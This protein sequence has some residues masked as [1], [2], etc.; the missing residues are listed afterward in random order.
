MSGGAVA[1]GQ[2]SVALAGD[3]VGSVIVTG[4]GNT[5]KLDLGGIDGDLLNLLLKRGPEAPTK[6]PRP[7]PVQV[8][9]PPF[10]DHLDREDET[11]TVL[12]RAGPGAPVNVYGEEGVGKTYLL[13]HAAN[14]PGAQ[15]GAPD[16]VVFLDGR[17]GQR[18][19][20]LQQLFDELFE[21]QP[22]VVQPEA[23]N[24]RDLR[25]KQ[26][27]VVIDSFELERDEAQRLFAGAPGCRFVVASSSRLV[28]EGTPLQLGGLSPA[29]ALAIVERELGPLVGAEQAAAGA[30]GAALG[31]NAL[32]IRQAA[33]VARDEGIQLAE[34]ADWLAGASGRAGLVDKALDATSPDERQVLSTLAAFGTALVGT[35]HL[36]A[37]TGDPAVEITLASLERRRLVGAHS[38]RHSLRG[39]SAADVEQRWGAEVE[40][41]AERATTHMAEW[42]KARREDLGGLVDQSEALLVALRSA[43]RRG[44]SDEVA[45]LARALGAAL[46]WSRRWGRW[47]DVLETALA[48]SRRQRDPVTEAW[49]LHQLGTRAV[50]LGE[51][52]EGVASL[53]AALVIREAV[54]TDGEVALT[55]HNLDVALGLGAP[56]PRGRVPHLRVL[57]V[58]LLVAA[59]AAA[60]AAFLALRS[61]TVSL[62][63]ATTGR[64]AVTSTPAG[65][66]CGSSCSGRF[67]KGDRVT[68]TA[69]AARGAVFAGWQGAGC[70]G[71]GPCTTEVQED[72]SV[73]AVFETVPTT[74]Q[75]TVTV[76]GAGGTVTS[77]PSGIDCGRSCAA[78][79]A[80][81]AR[82]T[83]RANATKGM[84]FTGWE[85]GG[86]SGIGPCTVTMR[87]D[88]PLA[89]RFDTATV[90][91]Q[92]LTVKNSGGGGTV[93]SEPS[94][95]DCGQSCRA[96][97]EEGSTVTLTASPA[98][99][100]VFR[101]W[102]GGGCSGTGP[103]TVTMTEARAV[104]AVFQPPRT[105]KV[106]FERGGGTV[107]SSPA[108]ISCVA[109]CTAGFADGTLVTLTASGD[110]NVFF[111][112][113][114][115]P[116]EGAPT[117]RCAVR[118][119]G[120]VTV[121]AIFQANIR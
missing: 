32:A 78:S 36:A 55:R 25:D 83:L 73:R 31:H 44:R 66:D 58:G 65:I 38:P 85:G 41:K 19:D 48:S 29:D 18:Q 60:G 99:D 8:R 2:G 26:V 11:A 33:S 90:A 119:T 23:Q 68:L 27:L 76:I 107:T 105:L 7:T 35:E 5:V 40:S 67:R 94:G 113:W 30:V 109:T 92:L 72:A 21:C 116:C 57:G 17:D 120:D 13:T 106:V 112:R 88:T 121:T 51:V 53:R 39:I 114:E 4:T 22:P 91:T 45:S 118:L 47:H 96:S 110:E 52:A 15:S 74:R 37:L 108:G 43:A 56:P 80:D 101:G 84:V 49:A 24:R 93:T 111:V 77:T 71:T 6:R 86:C 63:V 61:P 1:E 87:R 20:L 89:A 115:G 102:R 75:L 3:A 10:A 97:F 79:F 28:W 62:T 46:S 104:T 70:S 95:I 64:G 81:G 16:G 59:V 117:E 98:N 34:V 82:V 42:A 9:P 103:C 69:T 12:G 100:A 54:G 50:A 14:Q